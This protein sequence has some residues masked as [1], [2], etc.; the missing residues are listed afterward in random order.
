MCGISGLAN[1]GDAET[2]A[3]EAKR[4]GSAVG[5]LAVCVPFLLVG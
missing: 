4:Y 5:L 3:E 1:W 2:L